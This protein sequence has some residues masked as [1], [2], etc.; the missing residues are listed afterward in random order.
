M[1]VWPPQIAL[2]IVG[3]VITLPSSEIGPGCCTWVVVYVH[4]VSCPDRGG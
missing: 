4:H 3:T 1:I 2:W